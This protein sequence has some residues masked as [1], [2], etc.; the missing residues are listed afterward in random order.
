ML[1]QKTKAFYKNPLGWL[2]LEAQNGR[3]SALE[4]TQR[5]QKSAESPVLKQCRSQLK[6]YFSGCRKKFSLP[7]AITSTAFENKVLR[8]LLKIPCGKT[9]SYK[10]TA[11]RAGN[12]KAVRAAANAVAKNRIA[13]IIPCHRVIGSDGSLTGYAYGLKKKKW[14]LELEA[15]TGPASA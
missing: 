11:K 13:I 14:L 6:E 4:F 9:I 5:P 15:R 7:L 8:E 10:E 3:L 12:S 2:K 1:D